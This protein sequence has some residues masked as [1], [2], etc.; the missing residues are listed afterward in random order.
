MW[1]PLVVRRHR[2]LAGWLAALLAIVGLHLYFNTNDVDNVPASYRFKKLKQ[3]ENLQAGEG[4]Q[5]SA[6]SS[7]AQDG[8]QE[9]NTEKKDSSK[10]DPK[11]SPPNSWRS[12]ERNPGRMS[13][14]KT[15]SFDRK[16]RKLY[17][18]PPNE[19]PMK[20]LPQAI[21]IGTGKCGTRALLEYLA[22]HPYVVHA[23]HE[24]HFFDRDENFSK[25]LDWYRAQM[26]ASYSNQ[27]TVEKSPAY[28][29]HARSAPEIYKMDRS[30]RLV[31]VVKDPVVRLMSAVAI[32]Q[33]GPPQHFYLERVKGSLAI[34]KYNN[35]VDRG[36]YIVHLRKWLKFFPL[37]QIHI[38]DGG[39]LKREPVDGM[40]RV[41]HFLGLPPLLGP[42]NFY[43][44]ATKGFYCRVLFSASRPSCLGKSKG[45]KHPHLNDTVKALLYDFYRPYNEEFF[46]AIG[47]RFDWEP[48]DYT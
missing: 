21:V 8:S 34:K 39:A 44:N 14:K 36:K 41:E 35:A 19:T 9:T 17:E 23:S 40:Q 16:H 20:R 12:G 43:Y 28:V 26:P 48:K 30:V 15:S 4:S 32:Q 11:D 27:V 10:R 38:M 47:R 22:I 31:W 2:V 29:E 1:L 25:G 3:E 6:L 18:P 13:S 45:R 24:V 37:S 33:S 46:E 42:S 5:V 7:D